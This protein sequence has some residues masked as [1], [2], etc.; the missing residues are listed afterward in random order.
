MHVNFLRPGA[1]EDVLCHTIFVQFPLAPQ[2]LVTLEV[3]AVFLVDLLV[4]YFLGLVLCY[5]YYYM[6]QRKK[7]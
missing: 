1:L 5:Q 4:L 7:W 3:Y 6:W 2:S